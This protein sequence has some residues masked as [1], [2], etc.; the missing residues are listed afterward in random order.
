MSSD[1][2]ELKNLWNKAKEAGSGPDRSAIELMEQSRAKFRKTI[3]MNVMTIV[4][5]LTTLIGLCAF[6]YFLAPLQQTLSHAGIALMLGGLVIRIAIE[7]ASVFRSSRV[8]FIK[9]AVE[10]NEAYQRYYQ[11][12]MRI[13]GPV[14]LLILLAYTVGFYVL[15]PEFSN[16][17]N[18]TQIVLLALSY[19]PAA[20]IFG[21]FI[22][23]TIRDEKKY[24]L[25]VMHFQRELL[26]DA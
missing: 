18:T 11:Y 21:Y 23:K 1:L 15:I 3:I 7:V 19:L 20:A 17:F 4:I 26:T 8:D 24:L 9:P 6:F 10:V 2:N 22:R 5:L 25:D 13:H 16:Y 14:T 12:R